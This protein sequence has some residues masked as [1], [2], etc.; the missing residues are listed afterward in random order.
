MVATKRM[1]RRFWLWL[2]YGR[3]RCEAISHNAEGLDVMGNPFSIVYTMYGGERCNAPV[4]A[5]T[6]TFWGCRNVNICTRHA[7][8]A[9]KFNRPATT[10]SA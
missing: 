1:I 10:W 5:C 3:L 8:T 7:E 6:Q 2:Q 9:E 4:T